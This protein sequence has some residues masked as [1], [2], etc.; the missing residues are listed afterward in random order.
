M[1]SSS[2]NSVAVISVPVARGVVKEALML[3]LFL[4][5]FF[6]CDAFAAA[7]GERK[8]CSALELLS[9]CWCEC[10]RCKMNRTWLCIKF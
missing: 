4:P 5:F 1:F 6:T 8:Q 10:V 2:S 7:N 3:V 9:Q